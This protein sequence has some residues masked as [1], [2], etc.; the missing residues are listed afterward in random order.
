MKP[1][2]NCLLTC[3]QRHD[4]DGEHLDDVYAVYSTHPVS[5]GDET[6]LATRWAR[7]SQNWWTRLF[8]GC[9][10]GDARDVAS[11]M[12]GDG[13]DL[14]QRGVIRVAGARTYPKTDVRRQ[15]ECY[16]DEVGL[17]TGQSAPQPGNLG[18][19][20]RALQPNGPTRHLKASA[21]DSVWAPRL[22]RSAINTLLIRSPR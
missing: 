19:A 11:E 9:R 13:D 4:R 3:C 17:R 8:A 2:L 20:A 16:A 22:R 5:T 15:E 18:G 21:G 10:G 12:A 6:S 1:V 14:S 7:P